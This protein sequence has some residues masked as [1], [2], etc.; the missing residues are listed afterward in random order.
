MT[1]GTKELLATLKIDPEFRDKIPPLTDAEFAQ[2]RE[3]ILEANEVYEPI[4]VWNGTVIDGHNRLK[5]I[6]E[7]PDVKWQTRDIEFSNKYEAFAWMYKNQLGRRNLTE[8]KRKYF[9]GKRNEAEKLAVGANQHTEREGVQNGPAREKGKTAQKI[10]DENKIGYGTV[11]RAEKLAKAIDALR[12]ISPEAANKILNGESKLKYE[13]VEK[14]YGADL[15]T[16]QLAVS[17]VEAGKP[18]DANADKLLT[19]TTAKKS[20]REKKREQV[21]QTQPT[22]QTSQTTTTMEN[23]F[24]NIESE[25]AKCQ[26]KIGG[27]SETREMYSMMQKAYAP[28]L[29]VTAPST[30]NIDDLTEEIINSGRMCVES[31]CGTIDDRHY[32]LDNDEDWNTVMDAIEDV[33]NEIRHGISVKRK[34]YA[35]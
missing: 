18:L 12:E 9:I 11:I 8:W 19:A 24:S 7:N 20:V 27:D 30:Y 33:I 13:Q 29:D 32:L 25:K 17:K 31:I 15:E 3:N 34:E 23:C 35:K 4:R 10:A 14:M 26:Q 21:E 16:L 22:L 28:M 2:L 1:V 6:Q 5:V